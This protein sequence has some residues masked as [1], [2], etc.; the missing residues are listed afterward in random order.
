LH[1]AGLV[2]EEAEFFRI[3]EGLSYSLIKKWGASPYKG[4]TMF[5]IEKYKKPT[6]WSQVALWVVSIAALVVVALDVLVWR[7]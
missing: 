4:T 6:N 2:A 5:E 1:E 7:A 3:N